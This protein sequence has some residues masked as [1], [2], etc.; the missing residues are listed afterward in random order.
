M[1]VAVAACSFPSFP[2]PPPQHS[3]MLGHL[4]SSQTVDSFRSRSRERIRVKLSPPGTSR[5]SHSGFLAEAPLSFQ[6]GA[7]TE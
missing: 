5:L 7:R 3:P 2:F 6:L 4:A 1:I